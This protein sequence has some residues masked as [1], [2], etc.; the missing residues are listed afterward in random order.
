MDAKKRNIG[1]DIVRTVA[2]VFVLLHHWVPQLKKSIPDY[3]AYFNFLS[4]YGVEIFFVLSGFLIG[5]ILVKTYNTEPSFNFGV[6][7]KF[8]IR[9]WLRTLPL[10][11]LIVI[12]N[13]LLLHKA[14]PWQ[15]IA[16]YFVFLQFPFRF[17]FAFFPESWSL[18]IEE[19]FYLTFPICLF[20]F[21]LILGNKVSKR[22]T[23]LISVLSF[24]AIVLLVRCFQVYRLNPIWNQGITKTTFFRLDSIAFGVLG[25]LLYNR[26]KE[27]WHKYKNIALTGGIL[28]LAASFFIFIKDIAI[29][30]YYQT[31]DASFF[32]KTFFYML[33]NGGVLLALPFFYYVNIQNN[34]IRSVILFTSKISYSLYLTNLIVATQLTKYYPGSGIKHALIYLVVFLALTYL[35]STIT[36]NLIEVK[37]L[38]LRDRFWK[39]SNKAI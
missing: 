23:V 11:Y 8:W 36:Y 31:G 20:F 1:L 38:N 2:I 28:L 6:I 10:Y 22:K 17:S 13:L 34:I 32:S 39:D 27:L 35:F 19:W 14:L 3:I 18:C 16:R 33:V 5:N 37:F 12:V 15:T 4:F 7:K 9:R 30:Y 24:I 29:N 21:S 25:A 26:S